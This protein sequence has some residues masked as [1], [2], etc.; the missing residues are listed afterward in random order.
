VAAYSRAVCG[1]R[2]GVESRAR[3]ADASSAAA[4]GDP[5][6]LQTTKGLGLSFRHG[7]LDKTK[8]AAAARL[9]PVSVAAW[10]SSSAASAKIKAPAA[11]FLPGKRHDNAD[12]PRNL[13]GE[14][15]TIGVDRD[16]A[17]VTEEFLQISAEYA[18]RIEVVRDSER[19][20]TRYGNRGRKL[21]EVN[22]P[23]VPLPN[24]PLDRSSTRRKRGGAIDVNEVTRADNNAETCLPKMNLWPA[25]ENE[26]ER[27]TETRDLG[28]P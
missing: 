1:H 4:A 28:G 15:D 13:P 27:K 9:R 17:S 19:L 26:I 6:E 18:S 14:I 3:I 5:Y 2:I 21:C 16:D 12:D 22:R 20:Y 23:T 10:R 25:K 11:R 24:G 7:G 8:K